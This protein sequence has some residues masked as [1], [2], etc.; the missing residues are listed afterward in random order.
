[1][2]I[3][4]AENEVTDNEVLTFCKCDDCHHVFIAEHCDCYL[5]GCVECKGFNVDEE[6]LSAEEIMA[7][8]VLVGGG[9]LYK[10][11]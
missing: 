4:F 6:E 1:M 9:L 10:I 3:C 7:I 8:C 11:I 5:G 2:A